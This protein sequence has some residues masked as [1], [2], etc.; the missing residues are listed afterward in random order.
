V[1]VGT[2]DALCTRLTRLT[3]HP[4][5]I[6]SNPEFMKEG[7]A[8]DDFLRP[9]RV[10]IGTTSAHAST[11]MRELYAPFVR[12]GAAVLIMDNR[13][14][15]MSK[16]AANAKLAARISFMNEI[17]NIC[18]AVGADV[19]NVRRAVGLD[20]RIGPRFL[21]PGV[22]Y[23]GSCF[24]KDV[25][26]LAAT[27]REHGYI[28]RIL[29]AVEAVN[30]DQKRVLFEKIKRHYGGKLRGKVFALWGLAFKPQTDDMREAPALTVIALLLKAGARVQ[31]YDPVAMPSARKLFGSRIRFCASEYAVLKGADALVLITEWN[32]FRNPD[33]TR[34]QRALR[35]PVIFDGRNQYE[36][37]EMRE[38]GFTYYSIGR[39]AVL[40]IPASSTRPKPKP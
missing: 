39:R 12:T 20:S 18:E 10:I 16:Y 24:P 34:I 1:P 28:P 31:A 7:A 32:E 30:A 22:G 3:K 26:A 5:D 6:V 27:A 33:F 23:G 29:D 25:Q 13:S 17:A 15:E 38:R 36:P 21:F 4:F 40:P 19:H 9:E 8:L 11:I 14:A 2:A 37:D 35:R